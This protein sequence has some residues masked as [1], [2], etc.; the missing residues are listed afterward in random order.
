MSLIAIKKKRLVSVV[1]LKRRNS[2]TNKS[3]WKIKQLILFFIF[4]K[5]FCQGLRVLVVRNDIIGSEKTAYAERKSLLSLS[6]K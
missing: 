4:R 1:T 5:S 3:L 6:Y 2:L